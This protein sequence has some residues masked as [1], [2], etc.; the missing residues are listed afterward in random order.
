MT[1]EV[2]TAYAALRAAD[3]REGGLPLSIRKQRLAA[4]QDA[5]VARRDEIAE[6]VDRD[7]GRRSREE[8]LIA[9][10][11]VT[12]NAIRH[13]RRRLRGWA[14]PRRVAVDAP[15]WPSRA[16]VTPQPLGVVGVIAPWNYPVQLCL[17]PLVGALS[18]GNRILLKPSERTPRTSALLAALIAEALGDE[19]ARVV[20]GDARVAEAI[21]R[22]P[23]GHLLFTGSTAAGRAV[24]AAAAENLTPVTLELGGKCPVLITPDSDLDEAA[25]L[26]VTGKGLNA[27]QTCLAPDTVLL[28]GVAPE[29]FKAALRDAARLIFPEGLPTAIISADHRARLERL[30]EGERVE[31][32][33]PQAAPEGLAVIEPAAGSPAATEELFGPLL[34]IEAHPDL[35]AALAAL[36]ARPAPLAVYAMT[37]DRG[38]EQKI[39]EGTRSGAVVVNGAVAHAAIE[40][41]PFGGVGQSGMGRYHGRAGFETFSNMRGHVRHARWT[42]ARL[43][44][45]PYDA[46]HARML[47]AMFRWMR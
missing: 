41:L 26:I 40:A 8:T 34:A 5:L 3:R 14:R 10:V 27:G 23:L 21:A 9:E 2:A 1:E 29:P 22:L 13:A 35:D 12:L 43:L 37:R 45:P 42:V 46:R 19:V 39:L 16:W 32:L 17:L 33:G 44:D 15:F 47:R 7:F 6:A 18:A 31:E 38:I 24:M 36:R 30:G 11:I 25:R 4:L 20:Q 28:A